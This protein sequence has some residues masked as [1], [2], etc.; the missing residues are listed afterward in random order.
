MAE[1]I[2]GNRITRQRVNGASGSPLLLTPMVDMFTILLIFLLINYSTA[3]Q[4][5]HLI[6]DIL[7]PESLSR[8]ELEPTVEVAV[9][10]DKIYVD[11]QVVMEDLAAWHN[12][13][14]LL[15]PPLY[16]NLKLKM[17]SYKKMEEQVPLFHFSG[18]VTVQA[19]RGIPFKLL[20]KV[21]YTADRADFP[22]ISLAVLQKGS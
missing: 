5:V 10:K 22:H 6:P 11:G 9:S 4:L 20:K 17:L 7:M 21:L 18:K 13:P 15:M 12:E 1:K 16:E 8:Q 19:D 14:K 3:G 2:T